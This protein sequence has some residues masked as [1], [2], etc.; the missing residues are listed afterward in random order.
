MTKDSPASRGLT[1]PAGVRLF[2]VGHSNHDLPRLVRLLQAVGV[3]AVADVRSSPYSQRLPQFNRP[4]LER[5][6]PPCGVA[7]VYLGDFLGG[8][9][10]DASLYDADG[11]V[12]YE[13]VRTTAAF[14][15]GLDR[16]ERAA[17]AFTVAFLCGEADPL[18]C[19]RGLMIAPAL[20]ERGLA[21]AHL[22]KDGSVETHAEMETRL[23][24]V[25]HTDTGL[26]DG[27][28]A[29]LLGAEERRHL[30]AE[31]YRAR[32]RRVAFRLRPGSPGPIV[33]GDGEGQV[34]A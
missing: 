18:D 16:L 30:L 12:N 24:T 22:R 2:S 4:E 13:R 33:A 19:H 7:Y 25:T 10:R 6:L 15:R 3:T 8:R 34:S 26:A 9:P 20:A 1:V 31:A 5:G 21:V 32:A 14:Q 11:R 29:D 23:L 17:A 27:L 28:F